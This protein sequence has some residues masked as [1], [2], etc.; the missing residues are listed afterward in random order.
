V[1]GLLAAISS[2][3]TN[4]SS[5]AGTLPGSRV[6]TVT[7]TACRPEEYTTVPLGRAIDVVPV[8]ISK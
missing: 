3:T 8:G 1:I 7:L 2:V 6:V 5:G 4:E